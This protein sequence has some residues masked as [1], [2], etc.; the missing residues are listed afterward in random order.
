MFF[1]TVYQ[2][3]P[4]FKL[5]VTLSVLTDF[6]NFYT[7]GISHAFQQCKNFENRFKILT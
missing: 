3:V 2:K 4:T 1:Y 5:S 7:S 6:Q